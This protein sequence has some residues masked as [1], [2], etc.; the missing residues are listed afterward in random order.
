[1]KVQHHI[2][3]D[4]PFWYRCKRVGFTGETATWELSQTGRYA[5]LE[6]YQKAPHRQLV[7]ASDDDQLRA[8]V[9]AWGP[10]RAR[11][12]AWNGSDPIADY[13]Y[14]R[15]RLTLIAKLLASVSQPERQREVLLDLAG[16][17]GRDADYWM[18]DFEMPLKVLRVRFPIP[19]ECPS[20]FDPHIQPWIE[21]ATQNEIEEATEIVVSLLP[22]RSG[23]PRFMVVKEG[24]RSVV[25]ASLGIASLGQAL[26]WMV[27][28]D[29]FSE[30]PFQFCVECGKLI[31]FTS[32]HARRFCP[33]GCAH[34]RTAREW[35]KRKRDNERKSNGTQKAR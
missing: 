13:R 8:F 7:A 14:E 16:F 2:N 24:R 11:L 3:T 25:R 34:R 4:E 33:D 29:I 22:L 1:M 15:N 20:G 26:E 27:W 21:G 35:Q 12:D 6:A 32:R 10:L 28:Q 23:L 9:R 31:P 17:R 18:P 5:L 30:N 19:G